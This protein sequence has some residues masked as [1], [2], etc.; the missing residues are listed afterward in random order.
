MMTV[1]VFASIS[2]LAVAFLLRFL[3]ALRRDAKPVFVAPHLRVEIRGKARAH[4][5]E[6]ASIAGQSAPRQLSVPCYPGLSPR[7]ARGR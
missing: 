2:T 3:L 4:V 5:S 7:G 1:A 6:T